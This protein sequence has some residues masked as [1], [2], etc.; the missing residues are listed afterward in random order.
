MT[1]TREELWI[2][3]HPRRLLAI[4]FKKFRQA[5]RLRLFLRRLRRLIT[6]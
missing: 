1:S 6:A 5:G 4:V 3:N 2:L